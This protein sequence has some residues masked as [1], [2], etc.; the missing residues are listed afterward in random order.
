MADNMILN[1]INGEYVK[2][3]YTTNSILP[4]TLKRTGAII[5][6]DN[7]SFHNPINSY[8][9]SYNSIYLGGELI[10]GGIGFGDI[11]SKEKAVTI[12]GEW[13]DLKN[14]VDVNFKDLSNQIK[15]LLNT[16][17]ITND[18]YKRNTGNYKND[19]R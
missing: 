11:K 6:Y 19:S 13:D 8:D 16:D 3:Y 4:Q 12:L 14:T 1:N 15:H 10:M 9:T 2:F 5:I 17:I 7:K 18:K